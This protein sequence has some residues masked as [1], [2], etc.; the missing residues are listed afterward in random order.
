VGAV[1]PWLLLVGLCAGC[2]SSQEDYLAV[3][4]TL[5]DDDGDGWTEAQGD[6]DDAHPQSH[7][8]APELC[9]GLDNDCD[10]QVDQEDPTNDLAWYYDND[11]DGAGTS[12][13]PRTTCQRPGTSWA[14]TTGDCNDSDPTIYPGASER[15]DGLDD[16]CDGQV[17][18][19]PAEDAPSWYLDGDGDGWGDDASAVTQC[20]PPPGPYVATGGD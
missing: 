5:V 12:D 15:C 14:S 6:C 13:A 17:D 19:A 4:T 8:G 18:E 20:E 2:L 10:G 7:P 3:R 9:D 11:G 1:R 16:D